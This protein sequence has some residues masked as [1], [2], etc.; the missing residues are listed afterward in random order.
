M[1][2]GIGSWQI[3]KEDFVVS[4]VL[5]LAGRQLASMVSW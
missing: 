1:I 5:L 2:P 4:S 3:A